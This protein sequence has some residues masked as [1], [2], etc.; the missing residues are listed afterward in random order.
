[1]AMALTVGL[2]ACNNSSKQAAGNE[3][4]Q[5][6]TAKGAEASG[7]VAEEAAPEFLPL[8]GFYVKGEPLFVPFNEGDI[9]E[10]GKG[11]KQSPEKY[12]VFL[13]GDETFDVAFSKE[14]NPDLKNDESYINQ[15]IYKSADKMKGML[16]SFAD[17]K[18]AEKFMATHGDVMPEG[19]IVPMEYTEGLLVTKDYLKSRKLM[20]YRDTTTEDPDGPV[21][22]ESVIKKVEEMIGMKVE[23]NRVA[24]VIGKDEY[25]FGVMTTGK[26]GDF[27]LGVYVLSGAGNVS[28]RVD[29]LKADVEDGQIHWSMADPE[30]Y[31]EPDISVV[32]KGEKG[33]EI[34]CSVPD[35]EATNFLLLRQE[36]TELKQKHLGSFYQ[37]YE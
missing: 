30:Y 27:A 24:T 2:C 11:L 1:M 26:K 8:V 22:S 29:T 12:E 4:G 25:E 6:P 5:Q 20:K 13:M 28:L 19:E 21:F 16:Y 23:K 3:A 36:G 18:V 14:K 33:L 15:Y 35:E 10:K 9:P 37:Q 31:T 34:F 7:E 32:T 17:V